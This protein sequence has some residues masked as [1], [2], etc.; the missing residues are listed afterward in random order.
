MKLNKVNLKEVY[1]ENFS[2]EEIVSLIKAYTIMV[3][4]YGADF[5]GC[6]LDNLMDALEEKTIE[7]N[8]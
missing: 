4:D 1:K 3:N 8:E 7:E 6:K 5:F 2:I